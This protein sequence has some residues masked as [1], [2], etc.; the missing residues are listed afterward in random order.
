[1]EWLEQPHMEDIMNTSTCRQDESVGHIANALS[2]L[3][4]SKKLRPKLATALHLERSHWT[5]KKAQPN[6]LTR[7]KHNR[8]MAP[9]IHQLVMLLCLFQPIP[10]LRQKLVPL[11]HGS[12]NRR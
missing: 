5:M 3:V 11:G 4:W 2:H 9:I 6:P 8:P 10:H 12:V 1:M 7:L